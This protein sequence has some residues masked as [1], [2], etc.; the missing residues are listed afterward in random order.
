VGPKSSPSILL[1]DED[2]A[3]RKHLLNFAQKSG[4]HCD[5]VV[6]GT[7]LLEASQKRSYDIVVTD[8]LLPGIDGV[9]LLEQIR[10]SKPSP[11]VIILTATPSADQAIELLKR[12]ALDY[13]RKPIDLRDLQTSISR[14]IYGVRQENWNRAL[15]RFV[16]E[17]RTNY[18]LSS[19]DLEHM[20]MPLLIVE[21]LHECARI[22]ITTKLKLSLAFQEALA[23]AHEH[24]NLELPSI[25]KDE[26]DEEGRDRFTSMK[27]KRLDQPEYG[28][29]RIVVTTELVGDELT[30]AVTNE[31]KGFLP[32][33]KDKE[34]HEIRP[35][36]CHG[37]GMAI[38]T[39]SVERVWY[40]DEGRVITMK[41]KL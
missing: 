35:S 30:I 25:W 9:S 19:K 10:A 21:R 38:I 5:V 37:R 40:S 33:S 3:L 4:W 24:G 28:N 29:R 41:Q 13:I 39:G 18:V 14:L 15:Y 32:D 17:E 11:A 34:I 23:N 36:D 12:G 27:I 16:E 7:S 26:F 22:D 20:T 1:G 2:E 6:G 8:L 31:G